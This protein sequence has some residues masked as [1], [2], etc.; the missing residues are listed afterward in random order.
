M[1]KTALLELARNSH[2]STTDF[3]NI[4]VGTAVWDALKVDTQFENIV[5][6]SIEVRLEGRSDTLRNLLN[7][8]DIKTVLNDPNTNPQAKMLEIFRNKINADATLMADTSLLKELEE[9]EEKT[10]KEE[11][12]SKTVGE[13]LNLDKP[14]ARNPAFRTQL[15]HANIFRLS[16]AADLGDSVA[17]TL[18]EKIGST[19]SISEDSLNSLI[20][21]GELTEDNAKKVGLAMSFYN[22]LDNNPELVETVQAATTSLRNLATYNKENWIGFINQS[23]ANHINDLPVEDY[24]NFLQKKVSQLFPSDAISNKISQIKVKNNLIKYENIKKLKELNPE[25]SIFTL[26][27]F[28]ELNLSGLPENEVND[29]KSEYTKTSHLINQFSGM[30]I[31]EVLDD[32]NL[33]EQDINAEVI[34]R[35]DIAKAFF[36]NNKDIIVADLAPNSPQLEEIQFPSNS[37]EADK[38]LLLSTARTYQRVFSVVDDV[39]DTDNLVKLGITSAAAIAAQPPKWLAQHANFDQIR[40][41]QIN[42]SARAV[43]TGTTAKAGMI[44]E[45]V[46]MFQQPYI[47]NAQKNIDPKI[48]GYLKEI[49]EFSDFFGH[50]NFCNCK[51]CNSILSPAAYFVDLMSFI[52][53]RVTQEYFAEKKDH[54]LS[55]N[56][57]RPD[58]WSLE[59]TCDNTNTQI[60]YLTLINEVLESTVAKLNAKEKN[61]K[62]TEP[63]LQK[64][65]NTILPEKTSTF[66]P[67]LYLAFIEL[68]MYLNHFQKNLADIFCIGEA[69]ENIKIVFDSG[70]SPK[71]IDLI[72]K[73]RDIDPDTKEENYDKFL[74]WIYHT[75]YTKN[76]NI[77]NSIEVSK[78]LKSMRISRHQLGQLLNTQFVLFNGKEKQLKIVSEKKNSGSIQND[79]EKIRGLK[80]SILDRMHRFVR[81]QNGIDWNLAELDLVL[82]HLGKDKEVAD[83]DI[84]SLKKISK[85]NAIKKKL[86]ITIQQCISLWSNIPSKLSLSDEKLVWINI[87]EKFLFDQLFNKNVSELP[88][89]NFPFDGKEKFLHPSLA[90]NNF[91]N[92]DPYFHSLLLGLQVS[93]GELLSLITALAEP[94]GVTVGDLNEEKRKISLS[95]ENISILYRHALL[96]K[97]FKI[98]II[99]LISILSIY[100]NNN[101]FTPVTNIDEL[102]SILDFYEWVKESPWSLHDTYYLL[103]LSNINYKLDAIGILNNVTSSIQKNKQ[104]D[105]NTSYL[106]LSLSNELNI[107]KEKIDA[108]SD[109]SEID[110]YKN[111]YSYNFE[112]INLDKDYENNT[113]SDLEYTDKKNTLEKNLS[114]DIGSIFYFNYL[115]DSSKLSSINLMFFIKKQKEKFGIKGGFAKHRTDEYAFKHIKHKQLSNICIYKFFYDLQEMAIQ[116][117]EQQRLN[118]L[119]SDLNNTDD[120][121]KYTFFLSNLFNCEK[122][123]ILSINNNVSYPEKSNIFDQLYILYKAID[124]SKKLKLDGNIFKLS[125]KE[126]T[127]KSPERFYNIFQ[128][129]SNSIKQAFHKHYSSNKEWEEKV[130]PYQDKLLSIKREALI[131]YLI[132]SKETPYNKTSDLYHYLLLDVELE[133]CARTSR[134]AAAIDSAQLYVHRCLMDLEETPADH[135]TPVHIAPESIDENEWEWRKNYRVWEANRKIFLYPENYLEPDLRDNKT[136]LFKQLEEGLLSKEVTDEAILHAY[137][138]YLQG[139]DQL[140]HLIISGAYHEKDKNKEED[141]LHLFGVTSEEPPVHY[142]RRIENAYYGVDSNEKATHW[143]A[144]EKVEATIPVRKVSPII[145]NGKLMVF[146]VEIRTEIRNKFKDGSNIFEG[147]NHFWQISFIEKRL[148]GEWSSQQKISTLGVPPFIAADNMIIDKLGKNGK[149]LSDLFTDPMNPPSAEEVNN[150]QTTLYGDHANLAVDKNY[151]LSGD[152]WD[153]VYPVIWHDKNGNEELVLSG[154]LYMFVYSRLDL[155]KLK[156][157]KSRLPSQTGPYSKNKN[158]AF[159]SPNKS[160]GFQLL[161]FISDGDKKGWIVS[162]EPNYFLPSGSMFRS[163][164]LSTSRIN[165]FQDKFHNQDKKGKK[166]KIYK[167]ILKNILGSTSTIIKIR[168]DSDVLVVNGTT[169]DIIINSS[170]ESFYLQNFKDDNGDFHLKRLSSSLSEDISTTLF[171][172]GLEN[173]LSINFQK[174]MKEKSIDKVIFASNE[175]EVIDATNTN[176]LDLDGAM[177]VY[178][179]EIFFHIPYLIANHLNSQGRFKDAERWYKFIF[180]PTATYDLSQMPPEL[181]TE[182]QKKCWKLDQKW[183]YIEFRNLGVESLKEQLNNNIAIEE[184]K[185]NPFSPHAI[186]RLRMSAYQ[187]SIVMKYV[188]NLVDW[189]DELFAKAFSASNSEY[190]REATLKYITAQD[191][192]GERPADIGDCGEEKDKAKKTFTHIKNNLSKASNFLVE[193]ESK[194][195]FLPLIKRVS[196]INESPHLLLT[197]TDTAVMRETKKI[198]RHTPKLFGFS[199]DL[200]KNIRNQQEEAER[201][202]IEMKENKPLSKKDIHTGF[203]DKPVKMIP[204]W[205]WSFTTQSLLFCVAGNIKMVKYWDKVDD[206]LYKM[207]HCMDL[208]GVVRQLPLFSPPIDP[209]LLAKGKAKGISLDNIL[210]TMSAELPPYRFQY[211]IEK[212][213]AYASTVQA[214]GSAL[215]SALEKRD[216]EEL[217]RLRNT[218]QKT[219]LNLT[220]ETKERELQIAQQSITTLELR[221]SGTEYRKAYYEELISSGLNAGELI[222]IGS[223][224]ISLRFQKLSLTINAATALAHLIPQLGAPTSM[225]YGGKEAGDSLHEVA[226]V[227]SGAAGFSDSIGSLAAMGANYDRR[228]EGWEHQK[229]LADNDLKVIK[230]EIEV[231]KLRQEIAESS[232]ELHKVTQDQHDEVMDFFDDKF[233]NLGLYTYLSS[234]LQQLHRDAYNNAL[235]MAQLAEQAFRFERAGEDISINTEWNV[236]RSGLL[237]GEHLSSSLQQMEK[238]FIETNTRKLEIN[239]NFSLMQIDP[240]ALIKLKQTGSCQFELPEFYFDMYYPGQYRRKVQA[241]RISIPCVVGSYTNVSAKLTLINSYIRKDPKLDEELKHVPQSGIKSI[242]T[243]NAQGDAGVFDLNFRDERYL[244]FEG[245]G[246][247]SEWKLDLP[248]QFRPFD[249]TSISDVILTISYTAEDDDKLR[250]AVEENNDDANN[251]LVNIA[252]NTPFI[253][254]FSLRNDFSSEFH[255]LTQSSIGEK[256]TFNIDDRHFPLFFQGEGITVTEKI[257]VL[258]L[259][260]FIN[261]KD[262][263]ISINDIEFKGFPEYKKITENEYGGLPKKVNKNGFGE[264]AVKGQHTVEINNMGGLSK[265]NSVLDRNLLTDILIVVKYTIKKS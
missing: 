25:S 151:T 3:K 90:I 65:Y 79:I 60:P 214:L 216:T 72:S 123:L 24:A 120:I 38:P 247:I 145:F 49:P 162:S 140:S 68:K 81:L 42:E 27:N 188:D 187:K 101:T 119:I 88:N 182:A 44:L 134:V 58:L 34:R 231:A 232:L 82:I 196:A 94:L 230:Q 144:W 89:G 239:Q 114:E 23:G 75:P 26:N 248:S 22:I 179:R 28:N 183:Q 117:I 161:T 13:L 10:K 124:V 211:L 186:A 107:E 52:D 250:E 2:L 17:E 213:K 98:S 35:T 33:S 61:G 256:I 192:L 9:L 77:I 57:R 202:F 177:G 148:S 235:A 122:N 83:L 141:V 45:A 130:K 242:A 63:S 263:S 59:L 70:L 191:I 207:R 209:A 56:N 146:W 241:V 7:S 234:S 227:L 139:F 147:Y 215:L 133:G 55:L 252:S 175:S 222:Q 29:I 142:Y 204:S 108:F 115:F 1:D 109:L 111:I 255:Q 174:E 39:D 219:I 201:L 127:F 206:R 8:N 97:L 237:A 200:F 43:F 66:K 261:P 74:K 171:N 212:A 240:T 197:T 224:L 223:K 180:N 118:D 257:V 85:I 51:H 155:Y 233:S 210:S 96:A 86:G 18:I 138:K 198:A 36:A 143:G 153:R 166:G 5:R 6:N 67:P 258:N 64:I 54:P 165:N 264:E 113:I 193:I 236:S 243:S 37:T 4:Q 15:N 69:S 226:G 149:T 129:A 91:E 245:A 229:G 218:H 178:L 132:H 205:G 73:R 254:A 41:M 131:D 168:T 95:L 14:I 156:L 221:Q 184:Y 246:A 76:N 169:K 19:A 125:K 46:T 80:S 110:I 150:A 260:N 99:E 203:L 163:T 71:D 170:T 152:V 93:E 172:K 116:D 87:K 16:D 208:N 126:L 20:D 228:E 31:D 176:T 259:A 167:H 92:I 160:S 253:R 121:N 251:T 106:E 112:L 100:H 173:L 262:F 84:D 220:R 189:G 50:Q 225:K 158:L 164:F 181:S 48:V 32:K 105:K 265:S 11:N 199:D 78:L 190:L 104:D 53:S 128:D 194:N 185:K 103:G 30:K 62:I 47:F 136:P 249:Y 40:A 154:A 12:N 195:I 157:Q 244:P 137:A 238:R 159:I 102:T 217:T 135:P 21:A